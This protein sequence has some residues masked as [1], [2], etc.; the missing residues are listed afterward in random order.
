VKDCIG[1]YFIRDWTISI[2]YEV[3]EIVLAT[4]KQV[5]VKPVGPLAKIRDNQRN[6]VLLAIENVM[7]ISTVTWL[8]V[9]GV[10]C[11]F[12]RLYSYLLFIGYSLLYAAGDAARIVPPFFETAMFKCVI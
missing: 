11:S 3:N 5:Q 7:T 8:N 9:G 2:E 12:S 10:I 1:V 4:S 6:L